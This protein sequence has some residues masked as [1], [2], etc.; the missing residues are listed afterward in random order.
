VNAVAHQIN[1]L[2]AQI[3]HHEERYYVLADPEISDA[4]FDAMMRQLQELEAV[5]PELITPDSPTQRV[6]VAPVE[7]F[8]TVEHAT[9]MLSLDNAYTEDEMRAF[10]K[11]VRRSLDDGAEVSYVAELKI[12]GLSIALTYLDGRLERGVTRG[13]GIR[14]EDVTSN[15]RVI[16]ALPLTLKGGASGRVEIRGEIYLPRRAF[17]RINR[18]REELGD[19]IFAN[20]RNAAAGAIRNL[21]PALVA[22]RGLSVFA[23]QVIGGDTGPND[24]VTHADTLERLRVWGLPTEPHWQLCSGIDAV[25]VFCREWAERRRT[26]GFDTDGIVVKVSR[27]DQYERLGATSKFPRWAIAFKFPAEQA[28]TRLLRIEVKVGRTG[29]VTPYAV[30]EPVR[31]AGS[32]IQMATLHNANEVVRKDIRAGDIVLVE[33]AGNVIPKIV[34]PIVSRRAAGPGSPS[35]FVMPT[36]CLACQ[37]QLERTVDEVV[38]RCPNPMCP[39]QLSRAI[40]HFASRGAMDIEGL[41]ESLVGQLVDAGLVRDFA[42]LYTL[43]APALEA[44]ERMGKKSAANVLSKIDNSKT[45]DFS[46]LLIGLGIRH[47][48]ARVAAVLAQSFGSLDGLM[49]ASRE[50]FEQVPDVGPVVAAS[51]RAFLDEPRNRDLLTRLRRA[52]VM[53]STAAKTSDGSR[54]LAGQTFVLTGKL[55][56]RS[57]AAARREIE[58]LGGTVTSSV[59]NQTRYLVV[60]AE[61][62]SKLAL[63]LSLGVRILDEDA[64]LKLVIRKR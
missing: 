50:E 23:Y 12:D 52:G 43:T 9:P 17:E 44:L 58:G 46:R 40:Q 55:A 14:G 35:P 49:H 26:L 25:L 37:M 16:R 59:S 8:E 28:T 27:L 10:D 31:L 53:V 62:G 15:V 41:G 21:D 20:P 3:C 42:D 13:V 54:R 36:H 30:L 6:A 2:R 24:L 64:F 1:A 7:G 48:G 34:K 57:R 33:K 22:K 47:V 60:G 45:N 51:V 38:W 56:S 63:A 18:E 32:A 4:E 5:H 19:Q 39:A 61:P 29:A 11:R